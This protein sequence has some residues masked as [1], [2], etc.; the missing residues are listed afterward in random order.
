MASTS[1]RNALLE[2]IIQLC[3]DLQGGRFTRV[4]YDYRL[5]L[6]IVV[7]LIRGAYQFSVRNSLF[8]LLTHGWSRPKPP[9]FKSRLVGKINVWRFLNSSAQ[10]FGRLSHALAR[11]KTNNQKQQNNESQYQNLKKKSE[12]RVKMISWKQSGV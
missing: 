1:A 3:W 9:C 7:H 11:F 6:C 10:R 4:V 12:S 8:F 2:A 5:Q